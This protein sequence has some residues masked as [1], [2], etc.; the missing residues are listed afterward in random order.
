V[1]R[2]AA[3]ELADSLRTPGP[4]DLGGDPLVVVE[5]ALHLAPGDADGALLSGQPV[6]VVA[7]G[8]AAGDAD[9]AAADE[10]ELALI[11]A[12]VEA[13]PSASV[14]LAL[15]LRGQQPGT[16]AEG[17]VAESATYSMLQ[18][19]PEFARWLQERPPPRPSPAGSGETVLV[20][21]VGDDL[22]LTL[23]RPEVRNAYSASVRDALLDGLAVAEADPDVRVVLRGEGPSFCSGGDLREFGTAADPAAA[24]RLRLA[25]SV[26]RVLASLAPRVTAE[27]H[28]ACVG[29]GIELPAFAARVVASP[30]ARFRLPEVGMGLVPGAG[31][32]VS[33]TRRVGRSRTAWMAL[34]GGWVDSA[35]ALRWGLVDD[36]VG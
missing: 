21:R 32:T 36:V 12:T 2:I 24:H 27:V 9:V 23:N 5:G 14:A 30:D 28:G 7:L 4:V 6:V 22:R 8:P 15:L 17:L 34:T 11:Q 33:V 16:V 20:D 18:C 35:T 26:G 10:Q 13:N 31:G 3:G 19:G 25:R 1:L 29:A